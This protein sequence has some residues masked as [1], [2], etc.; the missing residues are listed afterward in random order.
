M[1]RDDLAHRREDACGDTFD[2]YSFADVV[3]VGE[4]FAPQIAGRSGQQVL[5]PHPAESVPHRR[6]DDA[7]HLTDTRL[8]APDAVAGMRGGRET[9]H[10]GAVEVEERTDLRARSARGDLRD[11][12]LCQ[13]LRGHRAPAYF[14]A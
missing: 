1:S 8:P 3:E 11:R 13:R 7:E 9:V 6:L 12:V 5:E 2:E 4:G 10:Q 14:A